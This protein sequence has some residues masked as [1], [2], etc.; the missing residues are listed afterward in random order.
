MDARPRNSVQCRFQRLRFDEMNTCDLEGSKAVGELRPRVHRLRDYDL[1]RRSMV[2]CNLAYTRPFQ[3]E[4][5]Q[6]R[7]LAAKPWVQG[8]AS[9]GCQPS[10]GPHRFRA[11]G[12]GNGPPR[13]G[14]EN[15]QRGM[16]EPGDGPD[17]AAPGAGY[18]RRGI[19]VAGE[20]EE[21][22]RLRSLDG[23]IERGQ[24]RGSR[25]GGDRDP[26]G[27]AGAC[28]NLPGESAETLP[29][30]PAGAQNA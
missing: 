16:G 13:P 29:A 30:P 23:R 28:V 12:A 21:R 2:I 7:T 4:L 22:R 17:C 27:R 15:R 24:P 25:G 11:L 1:D 18:S 5:A 10:G 26:V 9:A 3:R 6:G 14:G 19:R 8:G 20:V